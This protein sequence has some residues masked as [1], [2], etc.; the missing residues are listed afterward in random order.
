MKIV[1]DIAHP[2][3][4]NFFKK[5]LRLLSDQGHEILITGLRRGKLPRILEN[6]L[7]EYPIEYVGKHTGSK[8]SIIYEANIKKFFKLFFFV[9]KHKPDFGLSVG[10]FNLGAVMKIFGRPNL[11][12]DDDPERPVNVMLEKLTS[13]RL[14]FPPIT[15]AGGNVE[16]M[17][18]LKEWA[19]LTPKYFRESSDEI[20]RYS[21]ESKNY[22]FVR[23]VSSG[24]LNYQ[25][26]QSNIVASFARQF[27]KDMPVLLSL[28]DKH[29]IDQYP[30][31]WILLE[32]PVQDI[33]SLI[34][35]SRMLVSS[36]DSMSREGAM[37]G[38]PSIY[39]GIREMK[40]NQLMMKRNML[41][42]ATPEEA[43]ALM[44]KIVA[45]ELE[46]KDQQAFRRQLLEEWDDITEF[47]IN[48]I[49]KYK[50]PLPA[51]SLAGG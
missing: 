34:Y 8:F 6:E 21:L 41:F 27:P 28:E 15:E 33:H 18:A 50:K 32:E 4:V 12:F 10:S 3:H 5:A 14:F 13:T 7:S 45:G 26:Q 46:V 16:T 43:P 17:Q 42:R 24:S 38:V 2:A 35:H 22:I 11:Q 36:G 39:C 31:D 51:A 29:T 44:K 40:A 19:Y 9:M 48:Q 25:D 20:S 23:E 49:H 37:L 1:I 30:K 47:I